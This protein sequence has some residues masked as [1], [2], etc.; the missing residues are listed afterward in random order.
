MKK[1]LLNEE[2]NKMRKMMGLNENEENQSGE[3]PVDIKRDVDE[4]N[5]MFAQVKNSG[6]EV[7]EELYWDD[8]Y[9]FSY[10]VLEKPI[11]IKGNYVNITAP[12][13]SKYFF[14]KVYNVMGEPFDDEID[15]KTHLMLIKNVY[16]K[17]LGYILNS[18][19]V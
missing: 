4:I 11:E 16:K 7:P 14:G 3:F 18:V 17:V 6:V 19:N 12:K 15:L 9:D 13:D 5:A 10:V 2:I 1:P 8:T